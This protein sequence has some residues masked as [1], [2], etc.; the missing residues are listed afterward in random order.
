MRRAPAFWQHDGPLPRLLSPLSAVVSGVT[1]RR[2]RRHGWY[3]PI[4]VICVGNATVGGA[5]KTTVAL[6]LAERLVGHRWAVHVLL[7]GYGARAGGLRWVEPDDAVTDVG[8][9]ALLHAA[10]APTW[11]SADRRLG[12]QAAV[13]AG[14][15]ILVMDDGLQNPGVQKRCS[16]LVIDGATGFGNARVLPAGPLR[17]PI[18]VAAARCD[19]AVLIGVDKTGALERL[20]ARLP[21]LRAR[22]VT[23]PDAAALKGQ[24]VLAFAGIAMPDKFFT[25]LAE[26]GADIVRR[27]PFPD[28]HMFQPDELTTLMS[29]AEQLHAL[30]V[31]TAKDATRLPADTRSRVRVLHVNLVWEDAMAPERLLAGVINGWAAESRYRRTYG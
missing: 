15:E 10:V 21:V 7:R 6:D 16:L 13:A 24:R 26:T 29:Q 14:A 9:E 31:T 23:A 17:E 18:A 20:P 12:A 19:A 28:H 4:P 2:M 11:T 27:V 3:C 30:P 5:G 22:L 8:D 25:S 1:A